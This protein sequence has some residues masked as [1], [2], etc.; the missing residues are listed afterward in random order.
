MPNNHT[1]TEPLKCIC[2]Y[3]HR[4]HSVSVRFTCLISSLVMSV[5]QLIH[6]FQVLGLRMVRGVVPQRISVSLFRNL[7]DV[8]S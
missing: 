2:D 1:E 4:F 6:R 5:A 3:K 8:R 7:V